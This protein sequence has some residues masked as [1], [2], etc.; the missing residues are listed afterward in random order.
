MLPKNKSVKWL[1]ITIIVI[2]I[3][4]LLFLIVSGAGPLTPRNPP[5]DFLI[6][7]NMFDLDQV[8]SISKFRSCQG[9]RS[10]S[11]GTTEPDSSMATYIMT[12]VKEYDGRQPS[13]KV[14]APFDGYV[15]D[16]LNNQGFSFVP[17]SSVL[18]WWPF[19]QYRINLAHVKA[20]PK[21]R[22]TVPV[23]A[24]DLVGY[25]DSREYYPDAPVKSLDVRI[26]VLAWPPENRANN[27]EPLKNMDS[28]FNYMSD[29]VFAEF[30]KITPGLKS[31]EDFIIPVKWRADH[32]CKLRDGGPYFDYM[33]TEESDSNYRDYVYLWVENTAENI[34]NQRQNCISKPSSD[35]C[36]FLK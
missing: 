32:P 36:D 14:Y 17:K 34:I 22:G 19:N 20:L 21:Y 8:V 27:G 18:P 6:T 31:R 13:V 7:H 35:G 25:D 2:I 26:G 16:S 4:F 24:G 3:P 28:M 5:K 9:H 33:A 11:Q 30:T 10:M 12:N 23:K 1:K 15:T 29:E